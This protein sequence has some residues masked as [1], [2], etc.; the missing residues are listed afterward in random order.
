LVLNRPVASAGVPD[1]R[2]EIAFKLERSAK[3]R[4]ESIVPDDT[5]CLVVF[6]PTEKDT[7]LNFLIQG[8]YQT[9]PARDNIPHDSEWNQ[10]LVNETV[11]LLIESLSTVK[12]LGLL[13]IQFLQTLPLCAE[14]SSIASMFDVFFEQTKK[15]FIEMKLIP[16][17]AGGYLCAA[18]A[19]IARSSG[20]RKLLSSKQL[21]QLFESER[22]LRWVT[23]DISQDKTPDLY[24]FLV[25]ELEISEITPESFAR[26]LTPEFLSNQTDEWMIHFYSFLLD[27]EALW[28]EKQSWIGPGILRTMPIIRR[29]DNQHV[30]PFRDD[31]LPLVYLSPNGKTS[32][33][34]VKKTITTDRKA[35]LFLTKLGI[36]EPDVVSEVVEYVLPAYSGERVDVR[37]KDYVGDLRKILLALQSDSQAAV[38]ALKSQLA[39]CKFLRSRNAS[40]GHRALQE[41]N[42][43][44]LLTPEL[45][46]FFAGTDDAWFLDL[47]LTEEARA[48][49]L[50][51]MIIRREPARIAFDPKLDWTER[52]TLRKN[53]GS[54]RT[55][56]ITDYDLHGLEQFLARIAIA[57]SS[58]ARIL[59]GTLWRMLSR[60]SDNSGWFNGNYQYHYWGWRSVSF[61]SRFYKRLL[62][63]KWVPDCEGTLCFPSELSLSRLDPDLEKDVQLAAILNLLPD[64]PSHESE[65]A[66]ALGI[67]VSDLEYLRTHRD[68]WQEFKQWHAER[69]AVERAPFEESHA[70]SGSQLP[71]GAGARI[72]PSNSPKPRLHAP[73]FVTYTNKSGEGSD[74]ATNEQN[75]ATDR[76]GIAR[77]LEFERSQGRNPEEQSHNNEGFDIK[78]TDEN[79]EVIRYIEVKSLSEAW[80]ESGVALSRPQFTFANNEREKFWLYVVER[81]TSADYKI[82]RLKSPGES[83]TAFIYNDSWRILT[84]DALAVRAS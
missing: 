13:S 35:L 22:P 30:V 50:R 7:R 34:V 83:V 37:R 59:G 77:V 24:N 73:V 32:F 19:R 80:G 12:E 29:S 54:N 6:F 45:E 78:S 52:R 46:I 82:H 79:G 53:D 74:P 56:T 18:E 65:V 76:A 55:E 38:T 27:Q 44:Y 42:D 48:E 15:A 63:A 9:T 14:T 11:L 26:F 72:D 33:P 2:V 49:L 69:T 71:A 28:R 70:G 8:P 60:H 16:S 31:G 21:T 36:R 4:N 1:L 20:L 62:G 67:E 10:F 25:Q 84:E 57:T 17:D 51:D 64:P 66:A 61:E 75:A 68:A 23:G 47:P 58:D 43:V 81:A 3:N 39:K 40:D 5:S 41:P